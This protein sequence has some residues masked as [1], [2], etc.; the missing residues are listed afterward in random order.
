MA[1]QHN[2]RIPFEP[3]RKK[4]YRVFTGFS[5]AGHG[6]TPEVRAGRHSRPSDWSSLGRPSE[7]IGDYRT[8]TTE[9]KTGITRAS[10]GKKMIVTSTHKKKPKQ[11]RS[12]RLEAVTNKSIQLHS[13]WYRLKGSSLAWVNEKA[14]ENQSNSFHSTDG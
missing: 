12:A 9:A 2:K 6:T 11:S 13:T 5:F 14:M 10:R 7:A 3:K 4:L 8:P 1:S